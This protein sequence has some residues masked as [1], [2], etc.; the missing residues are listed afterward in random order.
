MLPLCS[1]TYQSSLVQCDCYFL[2][3]YKT[4]FKWPV[5]GA[6]STC[7]THLFSPA[8]LLYYQMLRHLTGSLGPC[9]T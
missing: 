1:Q 5:L 4:E 9:V 7:Y 3:I 6:I 2:R 8:S